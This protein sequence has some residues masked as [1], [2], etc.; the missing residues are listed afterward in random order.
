[1]RAYVRAGLCGCVRVQWIAS[2]LPVFYPSKR[3]VSNQAINFNCHSIVTTNASIAFS[4]LSASTIHAELVPHE[5]ARP[6]AEAGLPIRTHA[7]QLVGYLDKSREVIVVL[8]FRLV[9]RM[10]HWLTNVLSQ[11]AL[12]FLSLRWIIISVRIICYR[13]WSA[14]FKIDVKQFLICIDLVNFTFSFF[15]VRWFGLLSEYFVRS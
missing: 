9:V 8:G 5:Y 15:E 4:L 3:H 7:I 13:I 6:S 1:M 12:E 10:L 14:L 2:G 11:L